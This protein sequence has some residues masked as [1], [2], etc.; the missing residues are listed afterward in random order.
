MKNNNI[1]GDIA[2]LIIISVVCAVGYIVSTYIAPNP[3]RQSFASWIARLLF[4]IP[5]AVVLA[6]LK[7]R[8]R[9][10]KDEDNHNTFEDQQ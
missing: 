1:T 5:I 8:N 6:I 2:V 9:K 3:I 10:S 4:I 7:G